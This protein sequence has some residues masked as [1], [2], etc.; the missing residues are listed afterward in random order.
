MPYGEKG[1]P[2]IQIL[3]QFEAVFIEKMVLI[4]GYCVKKSKESF[5]IFKNYLTLPPIVVIF[6][7][8]S[9]LIH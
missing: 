1:L 7:R 2:K 6:Y 9:D 8:L 5:Q 3:G 4:Y